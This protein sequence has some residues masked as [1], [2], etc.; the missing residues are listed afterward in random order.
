MFIVVLLVPLFN[1]ILSIVTVLGLRKSPHQFVNYSFTKDS[2]VVRLLVFNTTF[3]KFVALIPD[4]LHIAL[5][6]IVTIVIC[7]ESSEI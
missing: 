7:V 2:K 1:L 3:F 4:L 6:I 5:A